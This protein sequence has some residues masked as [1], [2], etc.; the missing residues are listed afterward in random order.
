MIIKSANY[1]EKG[2]A[3]KSEKTYVTL[4]CHAYDLS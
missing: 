3:G 4:T 1:S 2:M